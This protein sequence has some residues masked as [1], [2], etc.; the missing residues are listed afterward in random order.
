MTKKSA[1]RVAR[2][3]AEKELQNTCV[4]D[5]VATVSQ[6]C[7]SLLASHVGL[8]QLVNNEELRS[9]ITDISLFEKNIRVLTK[10][11]E[12]LRQELDMLTAIHKGKTGKAST[13]D[14]HM[15]GISIYEK[16][17]MFIQRHESVVMPVMLHILEQFNEAEKIWLEKK[18]QADLLDPSVI[19]DVEP[20]QP[21]KES[22]V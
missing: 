14:E 12:S 21:Q 9:C 8:Q 15:E 19:T 4:W 3:Q 17:Y 22:D 7:Y 20:T 11:L 16:Y 5:D 2:D 13:P 18:R 6:H 10:D 1:A